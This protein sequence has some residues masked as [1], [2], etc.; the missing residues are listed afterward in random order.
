MPR[1][2]CFP[3]RLAKQSQVA[4]LLV[5]ALANY[6]NYNWKLFAITYMYQSTDNLDF[7]YPFT[8][9]SI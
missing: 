5:P 2:G 8:N 7:N 6:T 9:P 4:R 1:H 3:P